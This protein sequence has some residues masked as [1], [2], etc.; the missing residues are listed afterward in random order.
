MTA[1]MMNLLIVDPRFFLEDLMNIEGVACRIRRRH[2]E[3][4]QYPEQGKAAKMIL[5]T[6]KFAVE[7]TST[8]NLAISWDDGW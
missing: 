2:V 7:S 1:A 3:I 4:F 6:A 5:A 8:T